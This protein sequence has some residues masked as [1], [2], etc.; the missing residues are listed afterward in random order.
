M[1]VV[2]N[3]TPRP[4]YPRERLDVH[5]IGDWVGPRPGLDGCGKCRLHRIRSPDHLVRSESLYRLSYPG[6]RTA[7]LYV[8]QFGTVSG[9]VIRFRPGRFIAWEK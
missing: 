2:V 3:A 6:L 5:C 7:S 1:G 9:L 8:L 4:I